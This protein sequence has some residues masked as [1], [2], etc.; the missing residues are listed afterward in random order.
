VYILGFACIRCQTGHV[1]DKAENLHAI[2]SLRVLL[3]A[4][5]TQTQGQGQPVS[6]SNGRDVVVSN[7]DQ[8]QVNASGLHGPPVTQKNPLALLRPN[9][10]PHPIPT[11]LAPLFF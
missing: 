11:L 4:T 9:P 6:V 3:D 10:I 7:Q 8:Q 2:A 5:K 1:D